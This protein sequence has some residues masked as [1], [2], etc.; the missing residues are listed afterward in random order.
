MEFQWFPVP[1]G[2]RYVF[3]SCI[4]IIVFVVIKKEDGSGLLSLNL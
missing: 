1:S 2:R 3:L 4:F